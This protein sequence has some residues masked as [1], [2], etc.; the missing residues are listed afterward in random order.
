M[1]NCFSVIC[2]VLAFYF[3]FFLFLRLHASLYMFVLLGP[4]M[5]RGRLGV[6]IP[7]F[8]RCVLAAGEAA[9]GTNGTARSEKNANGYASWP[10]MLLL[11]IFFINVALAAMFAGLTIGLFGMNFITLEIISSAGKEPDSGYA[12]K[13]IP[14]RRYG[15]QL[16]ATLLIGNMLTMVIISQMVT[17][18]IQSTEFVNFIVATAVVFVFSEIIPM[19]VC[20]KGPYALWIGA[21]S[22]TI[23]SIALFLLY[24]VAK[25]LGMFLE[26]IVTHDEG[27]VYDRNEL[28]KLIRIHYEKY[29]NESGLGDDETR[30]II[31]ALEIHEANLTS[32]LKPLDRAVKLPGSIAITRKL[33]EQLW[34][35]GRSRLP[36]YSNDTYTH[37]TGILF[38]RALI[39]ITS[40]QM[41]NGIT[42]QDVVNAN[43]HDIVIVPETLSVNELLKIFLSNTSQLVFVERDSKFGNLN[44]SPD[45][46]SNMTINPVSH[47]EGTGEERQ[48][49][50]KTTGELK[51]TR[52][53][54]LTPQLALERGNAFPIVGIV[55]LEDVIE[56]FIKSD[57]YDEYDRTED[58]QGEEWGGEWHG[59]ERNNTQETRLS[60]RD[61]CG[62]IW[63]SGFGYSRTEG[64]PRANF[65]SYTVNDKEANDAMT[66]EQKWTLANFIINSYPAFSMWT[67]R[68]VKCFIDRIGDCVV[69]LEEGEHEGTL[70]YQAGERSDAFT[71]LLSGGV[72]VSVC[73]GNFST[74]KR[75]FSAFGE[76]IFLHEGCFLPEYTAVI[77]RTSRYLRFTIKQF[78][79]EEERVRNG[80]GL[81]S[82]TGLVIDES[83]AEDKRCEDCEEL[84]LA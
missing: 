42:V 32:I 1:D 58:E 6:C 48:A 74:E 14:I 24:P 57:I 67:R 65:Y 17:A 26:C 27:L 46:N 69:R 80:N 59:K 82:V 76:E 51:N 73:D 35:C 13:I 36:V 43:P 83:G 8:W 75:S 30:M 79:E 54:V 11:I 56:R 78:L 34:A 20:N 9:V 29:G 41:E 37:I 71:L 64:A 44:D 18:I 16:L 81:R 38:V 61:R 62:D 4:S 45:A 23:V 22:A 60:V 10:L 7:F 2:V 47:R 40:E 50:M 21:K 53:T 15:H 66:E 5:I 19:A 55:T 52:V 3:S 28:K 77:S 84:S 33:V 31:G 25:P 70:L 63:E 68:Q 39:N 49:L 12:R 72:R